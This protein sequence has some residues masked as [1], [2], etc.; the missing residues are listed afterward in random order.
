MKRSMTI[1]DVFTYLFERYCDDVDTV[2]DFNHLAMAELTMCRIRRGCEFHELMDAIPEWD[3]S[4]K[5][6]DPAFCHSLRLLINTVEACGLRNA[7]DS[8]FED[9]E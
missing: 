2:E 9:E 5:A 3:R 7:D 6:S 1:A 8:L 4:L